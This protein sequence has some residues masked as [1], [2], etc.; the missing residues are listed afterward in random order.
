MTRE[1]MY[2][3]AEEYFLQGLRLSRKKNAD[4]ASNAD[5]FE[6][7][8]QCGTE[9]F[10]TRFTDKVTRLKNLDKRDQRN[11]ILREHGCNTCAS[12]AEPNGVEDESFED[13]LMDL[14]NYCW[15]LAVYR[16]TL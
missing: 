4:Y 8:R 10:I 13:A 1:E 16:S 6:N 9:G 5:P 14:F 2:S 15:L 3:A 7:L 11:T 12:H